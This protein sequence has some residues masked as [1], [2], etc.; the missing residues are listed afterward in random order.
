VSERK[1]V[2]EVAW[3][4]RGYL[5]PEDPIVL[6]TH[7]WLWY[8]DPVEHPLT[9]ATVTRIDAARARGAAF[10]A[11]F[12]VWELV[13]KSS[14]GKLELSRPPRDWITAA[15]AQPGFTLVPQ[16]VETMLAAGE[17]PEGA[18]RD[19]GDR[20]IIATARRVGATLLTADRAI[21]QWAR[22]TK[23]LRVERVR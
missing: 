20:F 12:S 19:P 4:D 8:L 18:P 15:L 3:A 11:A 7:V 23:A 5:A 13:G 21:L 22:R 14:L 17:L 16:D 1:A 9:P 6:D 10:L 2:R